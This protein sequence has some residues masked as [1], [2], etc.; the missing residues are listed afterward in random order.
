MWHLFTV[1]PWFVYGIQNA[2]GKKHVNHRVGLD[3]FEY[4]VRADCSMGVIWARRGGGGGGGGGA[5]ARGW[6]GGTGIEDVP[7]DAGQGTFPSGP[8]LS[9]LWIERAD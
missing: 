6:L 8:F 4:R 9:Q 2:L 7:C 3:P 1:W 5:N